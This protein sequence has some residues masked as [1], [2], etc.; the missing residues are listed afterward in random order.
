MK[1]R[2]Q[3]SNAVALLLGTTI[4]AGVFGIPYVFAKA[5]VL[6]GFINL[7]ILGTVILVVNLSIGEVALR[8]KKRHMLAGYA[9][10]YLG[11]WGKYVITF[12]VVVGIF[13]AMIAYLI[14]EGEALS[15]MFGGIP[16]IYSLIF[17][18][19]MIPIIWFDLKAVAESDKIVSIVMLAIIA[20]ICVAAFSSMDVENIKPFDFGKFLLPY[21]VVL[22]AM[23]GASAVPEMEGELIREK[24]KLKN[25]II[26]GTIIP[27]LVYFIF[28]LVVVGVTG[29]NTTEVATI[30]LGN[31]MGRYMIILGNIF[32]SLAMATSFI[33]LGLAMRWMLRYDY[34]MSRFMSWALTCFAPLAIFLAGARSFIGVIGITGAVAGGIEGALLILTAKAAKKKGERKPE[35]SINLNWFWVILIILLFAVG[36]A[37]QFL[38]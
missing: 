36:I 34:G 30:G 4:G 14:G 16:L 31:A 22:F 27:L 35:Y 25:A 19:L 37:Y 29:L 5:G 20:F 6:V 7:L 23:I 33:S 18:L 38:F 15:A 3:F 32:A 28:S 2:S 17:F 13:G 21:G 9:Q 10:K 26:I 12:S 11:R 8:T 24:K 1:K